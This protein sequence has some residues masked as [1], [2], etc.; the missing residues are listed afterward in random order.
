MPSL[1]IVEDLDVVKQICSCLRARPIPPAV[2]TLPFQ[3]REEALHA[4]IDAPMCQE[5]RDV[6]RQA[7]PVSTARDLWSVMSALKISRATNR[8]RQ[9][10]MS[11]LDKPW[12]VR[13]VT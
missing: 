13:R 11:F 7:A 3:R 6:A 5:C 1:P 2:D 9:R 8:F 4:G 12:A 10:M